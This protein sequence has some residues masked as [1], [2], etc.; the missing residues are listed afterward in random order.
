MRA[1]HPGRGGGAARAVDT[2]GIPLGDR[3]AAGVARGARRA[4]RLGG[5]AGLR[6]A[7]ARLVGALQPPERPLPLRLLRPDRAGAA[8]PGREHQLRPGR[9]PPLRAAARAA[10]P[11]RDGDRRRAARRR[12]L[13]QPLAARRRHRSTEL[14]RAGADPDRLL[15]VEVSPKLPAHPRAAARASATRS[16]STRSTSWSRPRPRRSRCRIPSRREVDARDRRARA[17]RS[18]PTARRCRPGSARSRRRSS[19][20]LAEGDGG[21]YGVHSEMFTDG[22]MQLHAGGQGHATARASSTASRSRPSPAGRAELYEWLDGNDEVAFL[23]VEVVNSPDADRP[24]PPHGH[25]QRR[26]RGRHPR[27]GRRR[28]DRR[29]PVLGDRRPRG[30]RRRRRRSTLEDRSLL[31]LPSTVDDRRRAALAD[32]ALV[33]RR[34]P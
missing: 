23:P 24:Q 34:A 22:L 1:T 6:R 12:R 8:R 25:D 2:L 21:D 16:T 27:P 15:V 10:E 29:Q 14:Q 3:P 31:C 19:R 9:L 26:A 11:A 30:L 4:R 7:A 18:S 20:M 33:R 17:R 28:H 32:R 5:P 13:V